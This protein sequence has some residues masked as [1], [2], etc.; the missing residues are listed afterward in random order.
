MIEV[1][2]DRPEKNGECFV[3]AIKD[4]P[5]VVKGREMDRH[6]GY[7][8]MLPQ[9]IFYMLDNL[10]VEYYSATLYSRNQVMLKVPAF[11][12]SL[13][14][15][16]DALVPVVSDVFTEGLDNA[17]HCYVQSKAR[18]EFKYILLN[19]PTYFEL[20]ASEIHSDAGANESLEIETIRVKFKHPSPALN[21]EET[22]QFWA[23]WKIARVDIKPDKKGKTDVP[24]QSKACAALAKIMGTTN[25]KMKGA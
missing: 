4:I 10:T 18:R 2:V 17:R 9:D 23:A 22:T 20:S 24:G 15:Q 21:G 1:N 13:L 14:A 19:F 7:Y 6:H 12:C 25:V 5:S 16:R 8:I 3:F 11:P